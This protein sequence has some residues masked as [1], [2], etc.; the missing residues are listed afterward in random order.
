MLKNKY[1]NLIINL[2]L[3]AEKGDNVDLTE[4]QGDNE[5]LFSQK[6]DE[7]PDWLK[8][9]EEEVEE[10]NE[11]EVKEEVTEEIVEEETPEE[12]KQSDKAN[13]AFAEL[14]RQKKELEQ[15]TKAYDKWAVDNFAHL[16]VTD[17][18]SYQVMMDK[19]IMEQTQSELEE[20]GYD[21]E[22]I[23]KAIMLNPK[24]KAVIESQPQQQPEA[25]PINDDKLIADYTSL[26][27]KYPELVTKPEEIPQAVWDRYDR[28]YDLVEAFEIVNKDKLTQKV[29][30]KTKEIARQETL[31]KINSKKHLQTEKES[32]GGA[33]DV[34]IDKETLAMY[35]GMGFTEK[36]AMKFHKQH[37]K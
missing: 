5:Y 18:K 15:Q 4:P 8:D 12:V 24:L 13:S 28:G 17:F 33:A 10:T 37:M 23:Q 20:K 25:Q 32:G 30:K 9:D 36:Q 22:L 29:A 3:F 6:D 2:Q 35:K 21:A 1:P 7:T 31:N 26:Q 16:G 27:A 34:H 14:R 19:Q 11:E